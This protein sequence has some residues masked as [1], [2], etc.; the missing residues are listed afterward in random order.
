MM[1]GSTSASTLANLADVH[2]SLRCRNALIVHFSGAPKGAGKERNHLFPKDLLHVK[3]GNAAGGLSCSVVWPGDKFDGFDDRNA[4]GCIGVV[5]DLLSIDSLVA[6]SSHDCGSIEDSYGNRIVESKVPITIDSIESSL[7]NREG[8]NEWVVKD[9]KVLGVFAASPFEVS[10][11]KELEY[12]DEVPDYL[13]SNAPALVAGAI[14]FEELIQTFPD[15]LFMFKNSQIV[16]Y[17]GGGFIGI[18]HSDIYS[19]A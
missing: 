13:I 10:V 9:F 18:K 7:N 11:L 4:T 5:L 17:T 8:Y 2:S 14:K 16:R 3:L 19:Q 6:V 15:R 1:C 12:P